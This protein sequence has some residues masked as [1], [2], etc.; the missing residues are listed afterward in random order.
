MTTYDLEYFTDNLVASV[1]ATEPEAILRLKYAFVLGFGA[2]VIFA[3]FYRSRK[4]WFD[5]LAANKMIS[6]LRFLIITEILSLLLLLYYSISLKSPF[7]MHEFT[8][9]GDGKS[10]WLYGLARPISGIFLIGVGTMGDMHPIPRL[11]CVLGVVLEIFGDA[12]SAYQIQELIVQSNEFA[13][14]TGLYSRLDL[15]IYYYRDIISFGLCTWILLLDL[16]F[17]CA[18]G[19]WNPPFLTYQRIA[20]GDFDR[21]E[22]MRTQR[23]A[24][25]SYRAKKQAEYEMQQTKLHQGGTEKEGDYQAV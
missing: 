16:L 14:P 11:I 18:V 24:E 2:F 15:V 12:F 1:S 13:S 23:Q 4:S 21:C 22:V 9:F 19:I 6:I 3:P 20:G 8:S 7:I 25:S 10:S 17:V 5:A